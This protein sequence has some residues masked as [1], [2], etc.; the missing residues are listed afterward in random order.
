MEP[1]LGKQALNVAQASAPLNSLVELFGTLNDQNI[2]YCHWKSNCNLDRSLG[3]LT[4]LDL[5]IHPDHAQQFQRILD[6]YDVKRIV[7]PDGQGYPAIEDYLGFD[8]GTGRLFH[9]HVHYELV[10]GEQFVKN[11]RLPLENAF[12]CDPLLYKGLVKI[13]CPELELIVLAV[14]ALLKYRDRDAVK[15]ILTIRT[16]GIPGATRHEFAC[17]LEQISLDSV[18]NILR[19]QVDCVS[20]EIVLDL[21]TCIQRTPRAG[22]RLY[23]LRQQLRQE[24]IPYQRHSRRQAA[25]QYFR[26]ILHHQLVLFPSF[27]S[28]KTPASG[29]QVIA[30]IGAD[31]AGKSTVIEELRRWLS[32]KLQV[33]LQYMGSQ[34]PSDLSRLARACMRAVGKT[35]RWWSSNWGG[36]SITGKLLHQLYRLSRNLYHL[37]VG[38]DRYRRSVAGRQ[39]ADHGVTVICDRYPLDAVFREME[40]RPMDGPQIAAE[41]GMAMGRVARLLSDWE[42]RIYQRIIPPDHIFVLHVSPEV[43]LQRKPDHDRTMVSAKSRALAQMDEGELP[44]TRIDAEQPLEDVVRQVKTGVWNLL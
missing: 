27:S 29:G 1:T 34:Q 5:L 21:L 10:L 20:P 7:A 24:L 25:T 39:L 15:D 18:A 30:L 35:D 36:R 2:A 40:G 22:H 3:G 37:S 9:L 23:R 42:Q 12:L 13:P 41:T 38:R 28:R 43:S 26:G 33:R 31:G 17:L 4:D 32:W 8:P 19:T 14:R 16:P 44:I 6:Q 11:Y